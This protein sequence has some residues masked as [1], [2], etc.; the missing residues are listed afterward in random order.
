MTPAK[1]REEIEIEQVRGIG[2]GT[3]EG[4]DRKYDRAGEVPRSAE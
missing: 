3:G 2:G 4:G 1:R